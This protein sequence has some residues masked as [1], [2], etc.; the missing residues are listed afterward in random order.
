M[1]HPWPAAAAWQGESPLQ[2][3]HTPK[4]TAL[5]P[6]GKPRPSVGRGCLQG[7]QHR[8]AEQAGTPGVRPGHTADDGPPHALS[9]PEAAVRHSRASP[10]GTTASLT[11]QAHRPHRTGPLPRWTARPV[12]QRLC[13]PQPH[14]SSGAPRGSPALWDKSL[15]SAPKPG[16]SEDRICPSPL[17]E[18]SQP[19]PPGRVLGPQSTHGGPQLPPS[20]ASA[21][22]RPPVHTV[23]D[24]LPLQA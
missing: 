7:T 4:R 1:G 18:T 23:S 10:P 22:S 17:A 11:S 24:P 14:S 13:G 5:R 9:A 12:R 20:P 6:S 16:W 15:V 21:P 3:G 2:P 19:H 8:G